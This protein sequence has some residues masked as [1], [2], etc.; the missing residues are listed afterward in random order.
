MVR[1][2][3]LDLETGQKLASPIPVD[4]AFNQVS[5]SPTH[6]WWSHNDIIGLLSFASAENTELWWQQS[7]DQAPLVPYD[8][9][10][11]AAFIDQYLYYV[12]S[13][14]RTVLRYDPSQ[15]LIPPE[16]V[17]QGAIEDWLIIHASQDREL[18]VERDREGASSLFSL[19][20]EGEV[21]YQELSIPRQGQR[22]NLA[23][24]SRQPSGYLINGTEG[25]LQGLLLVREESGDFESYDE[26]PVQWFATTPP[27]KNSQNQ[28]LSERGGGL[29]FR[30]NPLY[31]YRA[32]EFSQ[33]LDSTVFWADDLSLGRANWRALSALDHDFSAARF[34]T[35]AY[36]PKYSD[37]DHDG[38][39]DHQDNCPSETSFVLNET[40]ADLVFAVDQIIYRGLFDLDD[41]TLSKAGN[42]IELNI[43]NGQAWSSFPCQAKYKLLSA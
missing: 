26:E 8:L 14:Q 40:Q 20:T 27:P 4:I 16:T 10:G 17:Y 12:S 19:N 32:N 23:R 31:P 28:L 35:V 3:V 29:I 30:K 22:L 39:P 24:R 25:I 42:N 38:I 7:L 5:Y 15:A 36:L 13:D 11:S 21:L 33:G 37:Q 2:K 18:I 34:S 1:A 41:F 43:W 6:A 9:S